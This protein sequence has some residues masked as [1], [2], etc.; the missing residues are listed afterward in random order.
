MSFCCF[1]PGGPL[2]GSDAFQQVGP[3]RWIVTIEG[4]TPVQELACFITSPLPAGAALGCHIASAPF[5]S[6]HYLGAITSSAPSIVFKT[7]Y[8]WNSSDSV[9]THVQF[10]V[11]MESE[12]TLTQ[13]PAERAS[14]DVLAVGR[15][16]GQD[17]YSFISSF[18]VDVTIDNERKIQLPANA[19]ERWLTRFNEKCRLHGLDWLPSVG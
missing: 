19:L 2:I 13:A 15:R 3:N 6:W 16:I 11:S 18:S 7:R 4:A 9:P 5:Q 14:A 8:V 10:G 12:D 17:I 1:V